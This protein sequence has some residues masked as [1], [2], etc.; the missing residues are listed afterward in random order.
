MY[1]IDKQDSDIIKK[2]S[3]SYTVTIESSVMKRPHNL[4]VK[5]TTGQAYLTIFAKNKFF[6]LV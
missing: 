4:E 2:K 5:G 1:L 6:D 3:S